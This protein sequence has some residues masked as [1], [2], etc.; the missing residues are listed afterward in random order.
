MSID[1]DITEFIGILLTAF[2][3]I[4]TVIVYY[5]IYNNSIS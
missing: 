1:F 4:I 2:S 3:F 5:L